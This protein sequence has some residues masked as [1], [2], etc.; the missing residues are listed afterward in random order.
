MFKL[1]RLKSAEYPIFLLWLLIASLYIRPY[2]GIM[3]P[4]YEYGNYCVFLYSVYMVVNKWKNSSETIKVVHGLLVLGVLFLIVSRLLNGYGY[5]NKY[6]SLYIFDLTLINL[7]TYGIIDNT[8]PKLK[9]FSLLLF[10]YICV[11]LATIILY[12]GGLYGTD[13]YSE[14]WYLGY[15][16]VMVRTILPGVTINTLC[17]I[18]DFGKL[19]IKDYVLM[20]VAIYSVYL[21]DSS[22]SIAMLY[23][24]ILGVLIWRIKGLIL[25]PSLFKCFVIVSAI[26]IA[27]TFF[28][29]QEY[30][31]SLIDGL[32][33]KD[34]TF[35]GRTFVWAFTLIRLIE[36]PIIGFGWH[37]AD[38]WR[39]VL[40]FYDMPGF[41][42]GFSHPHN[43]ILYVLL[44]GGLLYMLLIIYIF[45]YLSKKC[46][47]Y[48]AEIYFLTL[49]YLAFFIEGITESLIG[50]IFFMPL[51]GLYANFITNTKLKK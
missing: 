24:F 8:W 21:V 30:L 29:F 17:S 47:E 5:D 23:I 39:G 28:S 27:F 33:D 41:D 31:G 19:C 51:L 34:T 38:E 32:F 9:G 45:R 4:F 20:F 6:S 7:F 42:M 44:Q 16:N 22:T 3:Q 25:R 50:A 36:S 46:V 15:K 35:T 48:N 26:S 11:N 1:F 49:M 13:I 18:H 43:Y 14:N 2:N 37:T 12:P 10:I 40:G